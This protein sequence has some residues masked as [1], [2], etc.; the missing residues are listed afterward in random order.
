[1]T[2][3]IRA[4][5]LDPGWYADPIALDHRPPFSAQPPYDQ[6]L[7]PGYWETCRKNSPPPKRAPWRAGVVGLFLL[8]N[9]TGLLIHLSQQKSVPLAA[10]PAA[11][12]QPSPA[13]TPPVEVL[14]AL[15][16]DPPPVQMVP[17]RAYWVDLP[18]S[19][20]L[21]VNFKGWVNHACN[22]PKQPPGG[23]NNAMYTDLSTGVSWVWT[24]P[25]HGP[26]TPRWIDP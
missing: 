2:T 24:V 22:L 10:A 5:E 15:P 6:E 9:L 12:T 4:T 3:Q 14:R 16:A 18:D 8:I 21:K 13:Y 25:A 11:V 1:M 26:N 19:R 7:P 17:G 23:A 20:H